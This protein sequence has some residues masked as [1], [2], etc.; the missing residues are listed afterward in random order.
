MPVTTSTPPNTERL[1]DREQLLSLFR[2]SET[3]ESDFRIGV[4][5]EKFGVLAD[6]TA[7]TYEGERGVLAVLDGLSKKFGWTA[8]GEVS[9]GPI[10]SMSRGQASITLEPGAQIELSGAPLSDMHAVHDETWAHRDELRQVSEPLGIHWLGLGFHPF[11]RR[12][13]LSWVPKQRYSI[14][15][16]YLPTQGRRSLDMMQRT[17]TVQANYDFED[18]DDAMRKLMVSLRMSP[19]VQA[20]TA[21]APF[22]EGAVGERLSER[23]DVWLHMDPSRSGLIESLWSIDRPGYGDYVDWALGAGMFLIK[24]DGKIVHN[25]GQSF[26]DFLQ[27]GFEG[28]QAQLGDWHLHLTTLFPEVRLKSTLEVRGADS[29]PAGLS[30]AVPALSTGVLY[31]PTALSEAE[32]LLGQFSFSDVQDIRAELVTRGPQVQ[33]AGLSVLQWGKDLLEIA[34]AGLVRRDRRN[35]DGRDE[36]LYLEPLASL[37]SEETTPAQRLLSDLQPGPRWV[38]EV[39]GRSSY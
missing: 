34:R 21:N 19:I 31:D 12:E 37:I 20:L 35:D 8:D 3:P 18:E 32:Q 30:L 4:E 22:L 39:I 27:N 24:R 7:I 25:T 16:E 13:E 6:G 5:A 2:Q 15:K 14:M 28:H 36:S 9:G 29:L 33:L 26:R 1:H 11:A 23:G 17:A 10:I 38:E